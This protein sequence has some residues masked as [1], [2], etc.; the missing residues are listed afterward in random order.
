MYLR[1]AACENTHG[2]TPAI[3][4]GAYAL[5]SPDCCCQPRLLGKN[6]VGLASNARLRASVVPQ[7]MF[8]ARPGKP[9]CAKE[10]KAE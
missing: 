1:A 2:Q 9:I 6:H 10:R 5:Y 4:K 7:E 3:C 8:K